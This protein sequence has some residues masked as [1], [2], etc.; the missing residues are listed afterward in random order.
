MDAGARWGYFT[1]RIELLHKVLRP[2]L[3]L[4]SLRIP[5]LIKVHTSEGVILSENKSNA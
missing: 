2:W 4:T 1:I 3:K 5:A